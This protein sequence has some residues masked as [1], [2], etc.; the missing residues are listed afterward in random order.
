MNT[1][2]QIVILAAGKGTRMGGDEP[3][4]L[5]P[6][7]TGTMLSNLLD[8]IEGIC[9]AKSIL[10]VGYKAD[11]VKESVGDRCTFVLQEE[12][13]GTG[14]A[15]M[16]AR[17][18]IINS[19]AENIIILN[20]DQPLISKETIHGFISLMENEDSKF[21]IATS[22]IEDDNLFEDYFRHLGRIVRDEKGFI[23]K[24]VEKVDANDEQLKIREISP[25]FF[26][27]NKTWL[28]DKLNQI[29]NNNSQNEYYITDLISIAFNE[30][31]T[32]ESIQVNEREAL[33]ANSRSQLEL[34]EKFL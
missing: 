34:L 5:C 3:K 4:A 27:L 19:P 11:R 9:T 29:E 15:V 12:Q 7:G 32:I 1:D 26:C 16:C 25:A 23:Q 30:G 31:I 10:I 28:L 18:E 22:H 17:K 33:G 2:T 14:H 8:S 21:A 13:K 20:A 24:I 6:L